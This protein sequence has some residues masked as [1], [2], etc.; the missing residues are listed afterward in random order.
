MITNCLDV[1]HNSWDDTPVTMTKEDTSR[2]ITISS[3]CGQGGTFNIE[4][5]DINNGLLYLPASAFSASCSRTNYTITWNGSS[6]SYTRSNLVNNVTVSIRGS[7][8]TFDT[9]EANALDIQA[10]IGQGVPSKFSQN[11]AGLAR[12]STDSSGVPISRASSAQNCHRYVAGKEAGWNKV[13]PW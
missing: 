5:I 12:I 13:T 4:F 2:P 6:Y 9:A 3:S 1:S 10:W 8:Y 11:D 7:N